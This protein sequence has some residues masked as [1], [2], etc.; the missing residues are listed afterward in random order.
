MR[1]GQDSAVSWRFYWIAQDARHNGLGAAIVRAVSNG[2]CPVE[3]M[4]ELVRREP[5]KA[6]AVTNI[7]ERVRAEQARIRRMEADRSREYRA[8]K[9]Q[10]RKARDNRLCQVCDEPI[11]GKRA[12]ARFCSTKCRVR[13]QRQHSQLRYLA[14]D[15]NMHRF[16]PRAR[17]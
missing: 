2:W 14:I 4:E 10:A 17:G 6:N 8:R 12:D 16:K 7:R 11:K 5:D 13:H 3:K 9:A 15:P 1:Y